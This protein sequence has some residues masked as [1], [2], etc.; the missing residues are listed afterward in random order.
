MK[1]TESLALFQKSKDF[2]RLA[3][4]QEVEIE[5]DGPFTTPPRIRTVDGV[6]P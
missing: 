6:T 4:F 1:F 5:I 2:L 3:M